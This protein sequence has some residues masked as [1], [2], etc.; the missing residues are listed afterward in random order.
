MRK[1]AQKKAHPY[2]RDVQEMAEDASSDNDNKKSST[3]G[4][5]LQRFPFLRFLWNDLF[6]IPFFAGFFLILYFLICTNIIGIIYLD[7][8]LSIGNCVTKLN[9]WKKKGSFV[10]SAYFA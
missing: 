2:G 7:I 8:K 10:S 1:K 9:K 3:R 4:Q 5:I 6:I